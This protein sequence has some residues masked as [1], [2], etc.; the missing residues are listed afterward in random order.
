MTDVLRS[1]TNSR[2]SLTDELVED[3]GE[4]L[5]STQ[6]IRV[7]TPRGDVQIEKDG[8]ATLEFGRE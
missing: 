4:S 1:R 8:N 3:D 6:V 7:V 2:P 5:E